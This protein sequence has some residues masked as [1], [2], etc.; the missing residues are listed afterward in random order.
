MRHQNWLLNQN[1]GVKMSKANEW[2]ENML[3]GNDNPRSPED[4]KK[5]Q[6]RA[7]D[8]LKEIKSAKK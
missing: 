6:K 2:I 3:S 1:K 7:M 8:L 4:E 5:I